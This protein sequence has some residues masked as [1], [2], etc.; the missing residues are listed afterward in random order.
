MFVTFVTTL[1]ASTLKAKGQ[2][3]TDQFFTRDITWILLDLLNALLEP[4]HLTPLPLHIVPHIVLKCNTTEVLG[5][6]GY[7]TW[8]RAVCQKD[9]GLRP[10]IEHQMTISLDDYLGERYRKGY[11]G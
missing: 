3:N 6:F 2:Q 11:L 1:S 7:S 5:R 8:L 9:V 10:E 4:G